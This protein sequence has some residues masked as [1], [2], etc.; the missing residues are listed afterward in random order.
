MLQEADFGLPKKKG[1]IVI[2]LTYYS[3]EDRRK[4]TLH[5]YRSGKCPNPSGRFG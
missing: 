2:F 1:I 4:L 3:T 5:F